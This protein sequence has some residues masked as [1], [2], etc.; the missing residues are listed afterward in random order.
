MTS[1]NSFVTPYYKLISN[2][3]FNCFAFTEKLRS[4]K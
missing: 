2:A 3:Y 4:R 1:L